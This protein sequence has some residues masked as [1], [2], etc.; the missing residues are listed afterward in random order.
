MAAIGLYGL[1]AFMV[2][3][4]TREIGVRIALGAQYRDVLH[5][6]MRRSAVL[7]GIGLAVGVI[8]TLVLGRFVASLLYGVTPSDPATLLAAS[9]FLAAVALVATY[10]PARRAARVEPMVALSAE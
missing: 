9:L 4:R 2:A 6:V 7:V 5:L 10:V 8:S 1:V 3:Q